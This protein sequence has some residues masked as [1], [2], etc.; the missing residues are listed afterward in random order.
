[1][2]CYYNQNWLAIRDF[3]PLMFKIIS[4]LFLRGKNDTGVTTI[5]LG[6]TFKDTYGL[7]GKY[8]IQNYTSIC[9]DK[10]EI[11]IIDTIKIINNLKAEIIRKDLYE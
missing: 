4:S 5:L 6:L 10:N 1:M 7:Y 3:T 2:T 9:L 8:T 11:S